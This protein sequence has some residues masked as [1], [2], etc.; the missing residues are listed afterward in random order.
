VPPILVLAPAIRSP[1]RSIAVFGSAQPVSGSNVT[2]VAMPPIPDGLNTNTGPRA[3]RSRCV[4]SNRSA[5]V[6]VATTAPGASMIRQ[7][8]STDL[9][10]RGPPKVSFTSSQDAH[11]HNQ[12]TLHNRYANSEVGTRN[13]RQKPMSR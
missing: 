5:R 7:I 2:S 1:A 3:A 9:P 4:F 8:S 10:C 12:P 11:T 13:R 6:L